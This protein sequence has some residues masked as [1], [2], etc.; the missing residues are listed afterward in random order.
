M[1]LG[2]D[3]SVLHFGDLPA[4]R[5]HIFSAPPPCGEVNQV[6]IASNNALFY[7]S[8]QLQEHSV[9]DFSGQGKPTL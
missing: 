9:T 7:P 6:K 3:L 4:D 2:E 1:S 5:K 8:P